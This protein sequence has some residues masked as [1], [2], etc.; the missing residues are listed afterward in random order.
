[1][2]VYK[3]QNITKYSRRSKLGNWL[4]SIVICNSCH[5][6]IIELIQTPIPLF[7]D[8]SSRPN[9]FEIFNKP[10]RVAQKVRHNRFSQFLHRHVLWKICNKMVVTTCERDSKILATQQC[11]YNP[12]SCPRAP[13][14]YPWSSYHTRPV[15]ESKISGNHNNGAFLNLKYKVVKSIRK[16]LVSRLSFIFTILSVYFPLVLIN[17]VYWFLLR[18]MQ[19]IQQLL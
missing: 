13:Y 9:P 7:P 10:Y 8:P 19:H 4:N 3:I 15:P 16:V 11:G 17:F 5:I 1:M 2:W 6:C 18:C 12:L 14:P